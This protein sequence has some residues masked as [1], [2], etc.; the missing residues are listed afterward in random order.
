MG[1]RIAVIDDGTLQPVG[2]PF[3]YRKPTSEFVAGFIGEPSM[4]SFDVET[5]DRTLV[6]D[7]YQVSSETATAIEG[8]KDVTL[9]IRPEDI[10]LSGDGTI[11][12]TRWW[13]SSN[14]WATRTT[15]TSRS[16]G[17]GAGAASP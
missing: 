2:T 9:G 16:R 17:T 12:S 7:D 10:E 4:N 13:T 11:T 8:Q 1:D 3:E 15:S 14:R 6:R 5:R